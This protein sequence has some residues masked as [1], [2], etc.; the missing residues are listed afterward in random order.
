MEAVSNW[1]GQQGRAIIFEGIRFAAKGFDSLTGSDW[2]RLAKA[3]NLAVN[4]STE[5]DAFRLLISIV[6]PTT[7]SA[8]NRF[9]DEQIRQLAQLIL[10]HLA[11]ASAEGTEVIGKFVP[12][13]NQFEVEKRNDLGQRELHDSEQ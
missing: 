2:Q 7:V 9:N 8:M 13:L 10:K 11:E 12:A 6:A 5:L 1:A 4:V 3:I